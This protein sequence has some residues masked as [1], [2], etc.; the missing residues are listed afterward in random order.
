MLLL[1]PFYREK[2]HV[3]KKALT[4]EKPELWKNNLRW[5]IT[6]AKRTVGAEVNR[7]K[8]M[9]K[10]EFPESWEEGPW[11]SLFNIHRK[12]GY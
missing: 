1:Q 8:N 3:L 2:K 9:K 11:Y 4:Q 7:V 6:E 12:G 10:D 5:D